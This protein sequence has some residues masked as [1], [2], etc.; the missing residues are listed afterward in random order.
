MLVG[1]VVVG[2]GG[3]LAVANRGR[4]RPFTQAARVFH[5]S[6]WTKGNHI[7]PTQVAVFP[8]R[9]VRYELQPFGQFEEAIGIDQIASVRVQT[10][11]FF[12][13]VI[14]E[15]TGSSRSIR[16]HGH[17]KRDAETIRS[18]IVQAQAR[19]PRAR[20]GTPSQWKVAQ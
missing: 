9:V 13:D 1:A 6:R 3:L 16:C 5:A 7:W 4:N 8:T 15:T 14:I 19:Q 12:G 2:L 18:K 20:P 10:R 11:L 17:S